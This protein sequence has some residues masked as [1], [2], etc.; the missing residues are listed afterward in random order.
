[1]EMTTALSAHALATLISG[2]TGVALPNPDGPDPDPR[3]PLGPISREAMRQYLALGMH[4][5]LNPQP[6]PP[7]WV[8]AQLYA[9]AFADKVADWQE[10]TQ[11]LPTESAARLK[12]LTAGL[13]SSWEEGD[14]LCPRPPVLVPVPHP[15]PWPEK[16]TSTEQV[17]MGMTLAQSAGLHPELGRLGESLL[18]RS[19]Q[20]L[21]RG[22]LVE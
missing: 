8:F 21:A 22:V 5:A 4:S 6:L 20:Q 13:I 10:L 17:V 11:I 9:Q 19:F 14:D 18:Q 3:G 1:M 2:L 16:F 7:R 12:A 15:Q